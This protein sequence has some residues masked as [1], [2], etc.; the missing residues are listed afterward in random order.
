MSKYA[1]ITDST[2]YLSEEEFKKY[3]ISRVSLNCPSVTNIRNR[4]Q[5]NSFLLKIRGIGRF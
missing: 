2:T 5:G 4:N 1:I 3:D